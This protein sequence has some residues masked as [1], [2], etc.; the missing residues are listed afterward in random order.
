M[1]AKFEASHRRRGGVGRA[2]DGMRSAS[3]ERISERNRSGM[4]RL[5]KAKIIDGDMSF[6]GLLDQLDG[7]DL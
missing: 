5:R 1:V 3:E 4:R 6:S 7:H 2:A